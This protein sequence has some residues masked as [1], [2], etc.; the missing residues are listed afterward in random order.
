MVNVKYNRTAIS[1]NVIIMR[2]VKE[3]R[4][5]TGAELIS[6]RIMMDPFNYCG[7]EIKNTVFISNVIFFDTF[8]IDS[9][10]GNQ[11]IIIENCTFNMGAELKGFKNSKLIIRNSTFNSE[12]LI[13]DIQT[14]NLELFGTTHYNNVIISN[15]HADIYFTHNVKIM[16]NHLLFLND[17]NVKYCMKH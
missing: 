4:K 17:S 8:S 2:P 13:D 10:T 5:S 12:L 14:E 15:I 3:F 6:N 7:C 16:D 9:V 11:N 1:G